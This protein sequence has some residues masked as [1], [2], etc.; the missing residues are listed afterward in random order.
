MK[1]I[2]K[3]IP[4]A[5]TLV[6]L[7][8]CN[9]D[10]FLG[11]KGTQIN[12]KAG[13]AENVT[14]ETPIIDGVTTRA[15]Y[16]TR[17]DG[18]LDFSLLRFQKDD[19]I[20]IYDA[21]LIKYDL[22]AYGAGVF[23]TKTSFAP[24]PAYAL[25][26]AENVSY[27]AW[28]NDGEKE[29]LTAVV[30]IPYEIEY[31]TASEF[32]ASGEKA[33]A[34]YLPMWGEAEADDTYGATTQ[35]TFL[36]AGIT[37][38]LDNAKG[39]VKYVRL[40]T[41]DEDKYL[42]GAFETN[43]KDKEPVLVTASNTLDK[44]YSNELRVNMKNSPLTARNII[45]LPVIVG[46]YKSLKVQYSTIDEPTE[47]D[48]ED[49]YEFGQAEKPT[50][51][52]YKKSFT[53]KL[54]N[55]TNARADFQMDLTT[56]NALSAALAQ[57]ADITGTVTLN[58]LESSQFLMKSKEEEAT[59]SEA[60]L[61]TIYVPNMA[62]SKVVINIPSGV[63]VSEDQENP[64]TLKYADNKNPFEGEIVLNLGGAE[65][66]V[67]ISANGIDVDLE[68]SDVVLVGNY[69][70]NIVVTN[71]KTIS[72]G[73]GDHETLINSAIEKVDFVNVKEAITIAANT[74][75]NKDIDLTEIAKE[76]KDFSL[77]INGVV[78][79]R[80]SQKTVKSGFA[81]V[82]IGG[83]RID[84]LGA[85]VPNVGELTASGN[86][87]VE[88]EQAEELAAI[89][90]LIL[91]GSTKNNTTQAI[92]LK[93]GYIGEITTATLSK[94]LTINLT[95]EET[96]ATGIGTI[97]TLHN[98]ATLNYTSSTWAG[99]KLKITDRANEISSDGGIATIYTASQLA[100]LNDG[101]ITKY[102]LRKNVAFDL[103]NK[104]WTCPTLTKPFNGNSGTISNLN[105]SDAEVKSG[106]W[107][108]SS[109]ASGLFSEVSAN[110]TKLNIN[111]VKFEQPTNG[112]TNN[113]VYKYTNIGAVAGKITGAAELSYIS[114]DNVN[115]TETSNN[116][117]LENVG[118]LV[119]CIDAE[120]ETVTIERCT[121]G[122]NGDVNIAGYHSLGG[123]VGV[124]TK[125]E[126][127]QSLRNIVTIKSFTVTKGLAANAISDANF[128]KVGMIFGHAAEGTIESDIDNI[129]NPGVIDKK[130][131]H[132]DE[133]LIIYM[134]NNNNQQKRL[135]FTGNAKDNVVG[136][137]AAG[138]KLILDGDDEQE[139]VYVSETAN[140]S[141]NEQTQGS[142]LE[143]DDVFNVFVASKD[144]VK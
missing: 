138:V 23:T 105:L 50:T 45:T 33:Y 61:Y 139:N 52:N 3:F 130:A 104:P 84:A 132:F 77:N 22:Y 87:I 129:T 143:A 136:F 71:A 98:K 4:A 99:E 96:G 28:G 140:I 72:F 131:L 5:L 128:G 40:Y 16:A 144:D 26:P 54:I 112:N 43:L 27:A 137:C 108:Y 11:N 100:T 76:G 62:A 81:T 15:G 63:Q 109:N 25:F 127:A 21:D 44:T 1:K 60:Q 32:D 64:L 103:N 57:R 102:E 119:G 46:E 59:L 92:D 82:T 70:K 142:I 30:E 133:H 86:V 58:L 73:D 31:T 115:I 2:I 134:D 29:S 9:G 110:I 66:P 106:N 37:V 20:R 91:A 74:R 47:T 90:K 34:S 69:D 95:N 79:P 7:A 36:T 19:V 35:L 10:D 120:D 42:S 41:S 49:I 111:G 94:N 101:S 18:K 65:T 53:R 39:I 56:P 67:A 122:Q 55:Q 12:D 24:E 6:A 121:I 124:V 83:K 97:G 118:G 68:K 117:N 85:I 13:L 8:S 80:T 141:W 135:Y 38:T 116:K 107:N 89:G 75:Y 123:L 125:A 93:C 114:V 126:K 51:A 113:K 48:W 14:V 78:G 17:E 88:Q